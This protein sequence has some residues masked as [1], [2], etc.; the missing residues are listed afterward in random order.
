MTCLPHKLGGRCSFGEDELVVGL[1]LAAE[2]AGRAASPQ[3]HSLAGALLPLV[4]RLGLAQLALQAP[5]VGP[6]VLQARVDGHGGLRGGV[7]RVVGAQK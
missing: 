7:V 4:S 3:P 5:D 1:P 2:L 6:Q